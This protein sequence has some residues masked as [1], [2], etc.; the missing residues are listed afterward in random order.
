MSF[1]VRSEELKT[2]IVKSDNKITNRRISNEFLYATISIA[3]MVFATVSTVVGHAI[4]S[5]QGGGDLFGLTENILLSFGVSVLFTILLVARKAYSIELLA[6]PR[7]QFRLVAESWILT[8]FI[9]GWFVFLSD[10][11]LRFSRGNVSLGFL[12]GGIVLTGAHWFGS[13]WLKRRFEQS[14]LSFRR[15]SI[16]IGSDDTDP[17]A[18]RANLAQRGIEVVSTSS[19][20]RSAVGQ[21]PFPGVCRVALREIRAAMAQTRL[22][23]IYLYMPWKERRR[24]DELRSIFGPMPVPVYLFADRETVGLLRGHAIELGSAK[25]F[26]LQREPLNRLERLTKRALDIVVAGVGIALL[27]PL[28]GL[29]AIAILLETGRPVLFKQKRKGFGARPFEIF[30]FRSMHV[31]ENGPV[32]TQASRGDA[33]VTR[34]GRI[35]RKTS[36]DE[37]PQLF[38]VLLGDMSIVGPRPHAIAHDDHYS[39]LITTYAFRQHV[40]PGIT[41]WA[42]V[43]GHRGETREVHQMSMR[44]E[45]DIWYI[46]HWSIWLDVKIIALTAIRVLMGDD[47]Y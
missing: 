19:V 40:K 31:Q 36:V 37:L 24:I 10:T 8:Y 11:S 34:L 16:V 4:W 25:G 15:V 45:H 3:D 42:Q 12:V 13:N 9:L 21:A 38:N 33:R 26:E 5:S 1:S 22:D 46:N 47:A 14:D 27:S 44:I 32:V 2:K 35:L 18:I 6:E 28:L 20:A 41:G 43:N 39:R 17:E 23:A 7:A 30:K 29:T